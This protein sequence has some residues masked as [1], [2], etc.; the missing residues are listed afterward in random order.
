MTCPKIDDIVLYLDGEISINR[1]ETLKLHFDSCPSCSRTYRELE[2]LAKRIAPDDNEFT[3]P[4]LSKSI[5]AQVQAGTAR[6]RTPSSGRRWLYFGLPA[7]AVAAT[8]LF[9]LVIFPKISP[10][11]P[12]QQHIE[13]YSKNEFAV[14]GTQ[15]PDEQKWFSF[16]IF[17]R[18]EKGAGYEEV[19]LAIPPSAHLVFGYLNL[20]KQYRYLLIFATNAQGQVYWYYPAY[21]RKETDPE[22]ISSLSG[23]HELRDEIQHRLS[24]GELK[25]TAL[26]SKRPLRVSEIERLI[27]Q[28][29]KQLGVRST[30][31]R[32]PLPDVIQLSKMIMVRENERH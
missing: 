25:F 3:D 20:N 12:D 22:S 21:E 24:L 26:F 5:L 28:Q 6:V 8:M 18:K 16:W 9:V 2:R 19:H 10:P 27:A 29:R 1:A 32:L 7:A 14:R 17:K 23:R 4:E 30:L 13:R 15:T 31:E 11:R